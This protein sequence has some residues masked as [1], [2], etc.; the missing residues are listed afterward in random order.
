MCNQNEN[1]KVKSKLHV[2]FDPSVSVIVCKMSGKK[3]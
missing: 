3:I 1:H 2:K